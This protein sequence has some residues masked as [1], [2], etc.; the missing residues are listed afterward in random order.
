M[1]TVVVG[2][3]GPR[4][5]ARVVTVTVSDVESSGSTTKVQIRDFDHICAE[6]ATV[7]QANAL[8]PLIQRGE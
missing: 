2:G 3:G 5:N 4:P 7:A 6:C 8:L 1:S